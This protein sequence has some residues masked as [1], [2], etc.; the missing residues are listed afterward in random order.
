MKL[1]KSILLWL[2]SRVMMMKM[3]HVI[4]YTVEKKDTGNNKRKK[5]RTKI[6]V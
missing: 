5:K 2:N 4:V 1:R 3:K 6:E